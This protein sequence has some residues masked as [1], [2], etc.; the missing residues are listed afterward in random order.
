MTTPHASLEQDFINVQTE[1]MHDIA[2]NVS[3]GAYVG[4]SENEDDNPNTVSDIDPQLQLVNSRRFNTLLY[5]VG[6][7][8]QQIT[9]SEVD[10]DPPHQR[11]ESVHSNQWKS[12]CL[13]YT[14]PSPRDLSTSRMPSSA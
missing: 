8:Y 7:L 11:N 1:Q 3:P 14:S 5:S 2:N 13:L 12:D 4:D 9:N 6:T 10:I